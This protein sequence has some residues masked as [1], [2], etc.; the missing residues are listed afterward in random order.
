M[1]ES[2]WDAH[3]LE[4]AIFVW[5]GGLSI[6]GAL[7]VSFFKGTD[8]LFQGRQVRGD[9]WQMLAKEWEEEDDA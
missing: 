7:V 9:R 8:K 1:V 3:R 6:V 2:W 5:G 4:L